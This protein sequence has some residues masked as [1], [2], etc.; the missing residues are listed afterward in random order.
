MKR[1]YL[2]LAVFAGL[3]GVC[4][5]SLLKLYDTRQE[6]MK[7]L[8][9]IIS[10]T[11]EGD[12]ERASQLTDQLAAYWVPEEQELIRYVRH[13]DL[14]TI[15]M[16]VSKMPSLIRYYSIAEFLAEVNQIKTVLNHIWDSEIPVLR[17]II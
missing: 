17:N 11:Q 9:E 1:F 5:F 3:L 12:L 4:G 10:S 8:D 15:T 6:M 13:T 2:S 14:D 16:S 7:M